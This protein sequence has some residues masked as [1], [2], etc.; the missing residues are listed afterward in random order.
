M[1]QLHQLAGSRFYRP[2]IITAFL[3]LIKAGACVREICLTCVW[4]TRRRSFNR[5]FLLTLSIRNTLDPTY[6]KPS[7]IIQNTRLISHPCPF[8]SL[9]KPEPPT[10]PALFCQITGFSVCNDF[11]RL[12]YPSIPFSPCKLCKIRHSASHCHNRA[13][14]RRQPLLCTVSFLITLDVQEMFKARHV[15]TIHLGSLPI[16]WKQKKILFKQVTS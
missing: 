16:N 6:A 13:R 1:T 11:S 5:Q 8:L 10:G 2:V 9:P 12:I 15:V 3:V 14:E 4:R 7:N